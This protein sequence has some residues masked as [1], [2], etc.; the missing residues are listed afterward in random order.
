MNLWKTHIG[1]PWITTY[2]KSSKSWGIAHGKRKLER[3]TRNRM[4]YK[5]HQIS[6]ATPNYSQNIINSNYMSSSDSPEESKRDRYSDPLFKIGSASPGGTIL[7][8][9]S[10]SITG[11]FLFRPPLG[12]DL[13]CSSDA[14]K[15]PYKWSIRDKSV[16]SLVIDGRNSSLYSSQ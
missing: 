8:R 16:P 12:L 11:Y 14:S 13:N 3:F 4:I 6:Q 10:V 1:V 7:L 15:S 9:I 5:R 2:K